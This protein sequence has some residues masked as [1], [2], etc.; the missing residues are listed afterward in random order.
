MGGHAYGSNPA[1][2]RRYDRSVYINIVDAAPLAA[3]D[4]V[5]VQTLVTVIPQFSVG[6]PLR[7]VY[8]NDSAKA[9]INNNNFIYSSN[10]VSDNSS[11]IDVRKIYILKIM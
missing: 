2:I 7:P 6:D 8:L 3:S 1:P 5:V 9:L 11:Y 10:C 4:L